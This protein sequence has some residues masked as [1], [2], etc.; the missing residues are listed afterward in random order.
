VALRG[1]VGWVAAIGCRILSAAVY[2]DFHGLFRKFFDIALPVPHAVF[3]CRDAAAV[4]ES[5]RRP[6]SSSGSADI[7]TMTGP[8]FSLGR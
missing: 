8:I 3:A 6:T 2:E 5:V 4:A 7:S 1:S